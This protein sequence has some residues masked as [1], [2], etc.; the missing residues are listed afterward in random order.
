MTAHI[1]HKDRCEMAGHLI[2][3]RQIRATFSAIKM[4]ITDDLDMSSRAIFKRTNSVQALI[5]GANILLYC[6]EFDSP[7]KQ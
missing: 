2:A 5:A 7:G 6:N 3:G 4:I 1:Q